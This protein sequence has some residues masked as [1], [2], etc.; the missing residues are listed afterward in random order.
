[1]RGA[2]RRHTQS[3]RIKTKLAVLNRPKLVGSIASSRE[4]QSREKIMFFSYPIHTEHS[5]ECFWKLMM[6][7]VAQHFYDIFSSF[8]S[9]RYIFFRAPQLATIAAATRETGGERLECFV[10][11]EIKKKLK[12]KLFFL[13]QHNNS[14][15]KALLVHSLFTLY[16]AY[17][18]F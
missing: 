12:K 11:C 5:C 3:K 13:V 16:D 2:S 8:S 14:S 6:S 7:G 17:L 18:I 15:S 1:M 4:N 9:A 10:E